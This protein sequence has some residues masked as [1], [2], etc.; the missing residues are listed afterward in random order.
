MP[1]LAAA[2]ARRT[3]AVGAASLALLA[4]LCA[5][6]PESDGASAGTPS[7]TSD[8]TPAESG[9]AT[10]TPTPSATPKAKIPTDCREMLTDDVLAQLEGVPLNDPAF[11]PSGPQPDGSLI[12]IWADPAADTTGLNTS[13]TYVAR[14]PA[15][16]MLNDLAATVG[17]TCYTPDGGTRCEKT[18]PN[19]TYPVTDGRTLFWRDD[20]LIDTKYSNLAP[21][22][23]TSAIVDHIWPA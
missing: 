4:V 20:I 14:G 2:R 18:W 21:T 9:A 8:S 1:H 11:G 7:S 19:G 23:Y 13:I 10:P 15:L 16:D 22:G 5:C 6:A 12:C 17:F 3:I